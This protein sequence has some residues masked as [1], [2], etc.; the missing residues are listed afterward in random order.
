MTL[1]N[2]YKKN[3]KNIIFLKY[4]YQTSL[5]LSFNKFLIN[6]TY[7]NVTPQIA[8]VSKNVKYINL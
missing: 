6:H 1:W 4:I 8:N 5:L 7:Q 2:K 3:I